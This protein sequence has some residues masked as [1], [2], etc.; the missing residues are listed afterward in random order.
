MTEMVAALKG[1][2]T[3]LDAYTNGEDERCA[4]LLEIEIALIS[5]GVS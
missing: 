3:F 4:S 5:L 2:R 1:S